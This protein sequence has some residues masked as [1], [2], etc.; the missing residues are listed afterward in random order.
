MTIELCAL[1]GTNPLGLFA[2]LGV[3]DV[4]TRHR[5]P[6]DSAPR[7][8]WTDE[9]EPEARIEGFGSFEELVEVIDND[10]TRW[11]D[12]PVLKP[13]VDGVLQDD[14]KL[15]TSV[16]AG[17]HDQ[18]S[19]LRQWMEQ[20]YEKGDVADIALVHAL[21]AEGATM[22]TS[23]DAKPSHFHFTAGQQKFL[24]MVR[25][26]RDGVTRDDLVEA[27]AGPWRFGRPLPML[28]WDTSRG[29]RIYALRG[30]NP[31]SDKK[32]GVPGA[33]WLGF[34]GL[35]F[36]PVATRVIRG[37][38]Q[39]VTTGCEPGWKRGAFT[40]PLWG[41]GSPATHSRGLTA[42]VVRA[43]L[44]DE[45]IREMP[46]GHRDLLGVIRV[47]RAPITR[48]DQGGYGSFGP[49]AEVVSTGDRIT[50]MVL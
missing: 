14:V 43:L 40:W 35:R 16:R 29:D 36:F 33:D 11:A 26:L 5:D 6:Q 39:L 50:A 19:P 21:V 27:L 8:W 17:A 9:L 41:P 25:Q 34:L 44:A 7:L 24:Q 2:A 47:L 30:F 18:R 32:H 22:G 31:S 49:A 20:V 46:Q 48:S 10:R 42:E 37:R 28:G 23:A 38:P 4:A 13:E 12:S 45:A 15:S 3:L 1:K